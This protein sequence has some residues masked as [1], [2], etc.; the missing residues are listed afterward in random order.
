MNRL[1]G[2]IS[3]TRPWNMALCAMSVF[4]GAVLGGKPLAVA[5]GMY[6]PG[7]GPFFGQ[8]WFRTIAAALSASL[9][10]AAGN[11]FN[12]I[13]DIDTDRINAPARPIVSGQV[14]IRG[15]EIFAAALTV[16]GLLFA[17]P[18]GIRGIAVALIACVLLYA[19]DA[20]LKRTVAAGNLA[21]AL[22]GGLAFIYGGIAGNSI[23]RSLIPAVFAVLLHWAREIV[24]DIADIAGDRT[25]G[26]DTVGTRLGPEYASRLAVGIIILFIA[27]TAVPSLTGYFGAAYTVICLTGIWIPLSVTVTVLLRSP[28][29]GTASGVAAALKA[30]MPVGLVAVITGFQGI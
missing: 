13:C 25:A 11:V 24:K 30:I 28:S 7:P 26:I 1:R 27:A 23:A 9:I 14:T 6:P 20:R 5:A 22:L 15:A 2:Y 8:L 17:V 16:A 4:C 19:Y 10:L 21:V 29:S 3:L 18:L 12:D